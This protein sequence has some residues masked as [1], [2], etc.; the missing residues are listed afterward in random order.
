MYHFTVWLHVMER[1]VLLSQFCLS[2]CPSFQR[3]IDGVRTLPLSVLKGGSK[4]D[5]FVFWIKVNGWSSQALSNLFAGE[6]HKHLMA[7]GNVDHIH[8]RDLYSAARPSR[9]NCLITIWCGSVS[10]SGNSCGNPWDSHS[11]SRR[12]PALSWISTR[13]YSEHWA[14]TVV[15]LVT[16]DEWRLNDEWRMTNAWN[17]VRTT[18][19]WTFQT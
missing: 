15:T 10:G 1:T 14:H 11:Y 17:R 19:Q 16:T 12:L 3:A 6:C 5:F 13:W 4:S 7:G 2:V 8:G 9:R 18:A